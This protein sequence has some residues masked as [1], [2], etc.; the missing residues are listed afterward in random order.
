M[1]EY[2]NDIKFIKLHTIYD[3]VVWIRTDLISSIE[4][5]PETDGS[6]ITLTSV[7]N[8]Y[9]K[10]KVKESVEDVMKAISGGNI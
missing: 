1:F 5:N 6:D 2:R 8:N 9:Y 4:Y 10:V 7:N 3:T